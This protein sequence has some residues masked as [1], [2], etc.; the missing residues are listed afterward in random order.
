MAIQ[1]QPFVSRF[2]KGKPGLHVL[3]LGKPDP[4]PQGVERPLLPRRRRLLPIM[5][6]VLARRGLELLGDPPGPPL[7][8]LPDALGLRAVRG[9][10]ARGECA[11][12][13]D[14]DPVEFL[15][16][17][18]SSCRLRFL[19]MA[20]VAFRPSAITP[21]AGV[22]AIPR[23]REGSSAITITSGRIGTPPI[24]PTPPRRSA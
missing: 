17:S 2:F 24:R 12:L 6:R 18:G 21:S 13:V 19:G 9:S 1:S 11:R 16:V 7:P 4:N 23:L 10:K 5:E 3:S 20:R 22:R 14:H 8:Q 15:F